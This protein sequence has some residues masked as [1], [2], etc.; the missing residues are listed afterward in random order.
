MDFRSTSPY[1]SPNRG[2]FC[3]ISVSHL[4]TEQLICVVLV[5]RLRRNDSSDELRAS[6]AGY[7]DR[8][9]YSAVFAASQALAIGLLA[10]ISL[11]GIATEFLSNKG[12]GLPDSLS[13]SVR[14]RFD[15]VGA[16]NQ[17]SQR[18]LTVTRQTSA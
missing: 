14:F 3:S 7:P 15:A 2:D 8:I 16:D 18:Y 4:H 11:G 9:I 13:S 10:P 6:A 17:A 1:F 5:H 12:V